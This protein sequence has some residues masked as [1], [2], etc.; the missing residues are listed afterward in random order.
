M[1]FCSKLPWDS[2]FF[3]FPIA[4][5]HPNHLRPETVDACFAWCRAQGIRCLYFLADPDDQL[6]ADLAAA[7][8]FR[9]VDVRVTLECRNLEHGAWSSGVRPW[10]E[11]DLPEL[12]RIA[13]AVHRDSRFYYD[14]NFPRERCDALYEL[15]IEKSCR[16]YADAVFVAEDDGTPSGYITCHRE[17]DGSGRIGLVGVAAS[18]RGRGIGGEL[19]RAAL[20]YFASSGVSAVRVVTQ[21]RNFAAQRLYQRSGFVTASM[22]IWYHRWFPEHGSA[23]CQP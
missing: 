2:A 20:A 10:R 23:G 17:P 11:S 15:W 16:G 21:G 7:H 22:Q 5:L 18:A 3:G 19:V 13:R 12:R 8:G 9:L 4:R 6:T 1:E 14:T